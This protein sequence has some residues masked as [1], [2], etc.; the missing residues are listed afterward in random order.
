MKVYTVSQVNSYLKGI[1]ENDLFLN[2]IYVEGEISNFK[3]HSNGSF[4]FKIKDDNSVISAVMYSNYVRNVKF[5]PEDGMKVVLRGSL[6][7]YEKYGI[8]QLYAVTM[9]PAGKGALYLAF[10]QLKQRLSKAGVFDE[11]HKKSIPK[12]PS[13]VAVI[14]S[15]TGAAVR[16]IINVISRRDP[17]VEIVVVPTLVQ[18]ESSADDIVR[19]ISMV[20]RWGKADTIILGRGGGSIEDLWSFN[21]EKVARAIFNSK[22]PIISAVGHETDFTIADFISDLR[23]PTPSAAA[24]LAVSETS[25]VKNTVK[26]KYN[27]ITK[28]IESEIR[29]KYNSLYTAM[30]T[31]AMAG[32]EDRLSNTGNN[33]YNLHQRMD[34]SVENKLSSSGF[35][36]K[37]ALD[38]IENKSPLNILKKGYS[39][40]YK[41]N[42]LVKSTEDVKKGDILRIN[43]SD[44]NIKA[45]V[46]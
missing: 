5:M 31:R 17:G 3:Y 37:N 25:N 13:V 33:I 40:V 10:E 27:A 44:G 46:E 39:L 32:F 4:Y 2:D 21:E 9:Q 45:K 19:G 24:E 42:T 22:V 14:T 8:Y 18:G 29:L 15:P 26:E 36:L 11:K 12:F 35:K 6:S 1:I 16:D 20:N 38:N 7:L 43:V 28:K 34:R 23:A 30:H 41:D